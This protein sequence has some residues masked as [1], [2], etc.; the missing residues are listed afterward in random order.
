V[1]DIAAPRPPLEILY[2]DAHLVAVVKPAGLPAVPD[3]TRDA[4]LVDRLRDALV[5]RA[6][7]PAFVGP[8]HRI[9]RPVSGVVVCALDPTTAD[10]LAG[11]LRARRLTKVY[12]GVVEGVPRR[13]EGELTQWLLKDRARNLVRSVAPRTR[14]AREATTRWRTLL[15]FGE[16][17]LLE[18]EPHTG[19]SH[20]LRVAAARLGCPLVGDVKY[21]ASRLLR[22]RSIGLHA[23]RLEL[24][25]PVT[26]ER[27]VLEAPLPDVPLWGL[28]RRYL[29]AARG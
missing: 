11:Q 2:R 1:R 24:E 5:R 6:G 16:R 4:S 13:G 29:D 20:Q 27:L 10:A 15:A 28:G 21:G 23:R 17:A 9:D 18:L 3:G 7:E 22:D 25:H 12:W 14:G 19:R 26:R 8:A